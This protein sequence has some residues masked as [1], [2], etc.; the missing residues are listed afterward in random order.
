MVQTYSGILEGHKK[1][2]QVNTVMIR[3]HPQNILSEKKQGKIMQSKQPFL[4]QTNKNFSQSGGNYAY[5]DLLYT[6]RISLAG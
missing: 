5:S 2:R 3:N 1:K 6:Q 4:Y